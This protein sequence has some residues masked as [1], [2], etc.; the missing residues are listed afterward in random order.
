MSFTCL[1]LDMGCLPKGQLLDPDILFKSE[2]S[3]GVPEESLIVIPEQLPIAVPEKL[4][5]VVIP[6]EL[7]TPS[8]Y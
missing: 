7:S 5:K 6:E 1:L 3:V 4:S 8:F 2:L